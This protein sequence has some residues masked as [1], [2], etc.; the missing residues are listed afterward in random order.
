MESAP[1]GEAGPSQGEPSSAPP[2]ARSVVDRRLT[3]VII[4]VLD[5]LWK[6]MNIIF[7]YFVW[8]PVFRI[9]EH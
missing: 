6:A 5:T 8:T 4:F 7:W 3:A 2:G 1:S 9:W